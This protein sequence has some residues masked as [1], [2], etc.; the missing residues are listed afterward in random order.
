MWDSRIPAKV[1]G[2]QQ[3]RRPA[4]TAGFRLSGQIRPASR[5]PA[6]WPDGQ[7]SAGLARF[8]PD[9]SPEFGLPDS[10]EGG[11]IPSPDSCDINRMLSDSDTGNI[12][13]VVGYLN[14]KV[15]CVV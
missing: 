6:L 1:A 4:Q 10:G 7:N 13:M 15:D 2:F 12:S 5:N 14:V 8:R 3:L 11:R 9:W